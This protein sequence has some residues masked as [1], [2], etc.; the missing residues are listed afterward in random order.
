MLIINIQARKCLHGVIN[1][2]PASEQQS[3]ISRLVSEHQLLYYSFARYKLFGK[4]PCRINKL[5]SSLNNLEYY[6]KLCFIYHS[7]RN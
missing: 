2:C 1:E 5:I 3:V 7:T 4:L 6:G